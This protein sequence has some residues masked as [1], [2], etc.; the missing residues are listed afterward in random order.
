MELEEALKSR[1]TRLVSL[2]SPE[3][4]AS[5]I[6]TLGE[7]PD[8]SAEDILTIVESDPS[9]AAMLLR[10]ANSPLHAQRRLCLSLRQALREL[11]ERAALSILLESIEPINRR[12][13]PLTKLGRSIWL[14]SQ[15]CALASRGIGHAL[16]EDRVDELYLAGLLQDL[17]IVALVKC[18]PERY[19]ELLARSA[20]LCSL[21]ENEKAELG[22]TH[23]DVGIWLAKQWRLPPFV[24]DAMQYRPSRHPLEQSDDYDIRRI[25][26]VIIGSFIAD[27]CIHMEQERA[28]GPDEPSTPLTAVS[29]SL[30]RIS[31]IA[32]H[33]QLD[34]A[35]VIECLP[36]ISAQIENLKEDT[37]EQIWSTNQRREFR[38]QR[39]FILQLRHFHKQRMLEKMGAHSD[40]LQ[41]RNQ[42]LEETAKH[43]SMTGLY[44]R[45]YFS[46]VLEREFR[47]VDKHGASFSVALIDL[48]SFKSINDSYGHPIGD[49][50]LKEVAKILQT[51]TRDMDV[52]ARFGGDEFVLLL[53]GTNSEH[54]KQ[55]CERLL[56]AVKNCVLDHHSGSQLATSASIGLLTP[57]H[58]GKAQTSDTLLMAA[59]AA[60]YAAKRHGGGCVRVYAGEPLE[61]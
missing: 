56:I 27:W 38:Q 35:T 15:I 17:G 11:T 2:P 48:D 39:R 33:F 54:A 5:R 30:L 10:V 3:W 20:T 41:A 16:G 53:P 9:I 57:E 14:H 25:G 36:D 12:K 6:V 4:V 50:F 32:T 19:T 7:K 46:E 59:D 45:A 22:A 28:P 18:A 13:T 43:D 26:S 47:L 42:L 1:L 40:Y 51:Q 60:L 23:I 61:I 29:L 37:K 55:L 44:S 21:I 58:F 24:T 34:L 8:P 49:R 52:L 31:E